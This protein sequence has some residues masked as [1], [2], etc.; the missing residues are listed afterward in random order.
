MRVRIQLP[1]QAHRL[2]ENKFS[3]IRLRKTIVMVFEKSR[4]WAEKNFPPNMLKK[5][6]KFSDRKK[7]PLKRLSP[8]SC[9]DLSARQTGS[10]GAHQRDVGQ[11]DRSCRR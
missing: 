6:R 11:P 1:A 4:A 5:K 3:V 9:G 2:D 8:S 7:T 10:P